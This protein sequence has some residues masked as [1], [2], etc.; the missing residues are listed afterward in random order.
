MTHFELVKKAATWLRENHCVV[1]TE[2]ASGAGEIPDAIGFTTRSSTLIECKTSVMD[3]K[4]DFKKPYR[5]QDIYGMGKYRYYLTE[6]GLL[7]LGMIPPYWGL[8]EWNGK[9]VQQ[10]LQAIWVPSDQAGELALLLSTLRR[11]GQTPPVGVS[12]K[13]YQYKTK[14]RAT[15]GIENG[16]ETCV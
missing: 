14:N 12:I 9:Y 8:L 15:V 1:I 2:L 5:Q 4:T 6:K 13:C 11:I 10:T 3:F 7:E 16:E